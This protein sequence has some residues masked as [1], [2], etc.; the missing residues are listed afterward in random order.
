MICLFCKSDSHNSKTIEHIIPHSLGNSKFTLPKGIVCDKCNHYFAVKIE[1][2]VLEL[3]F[4]INIRF[5][6]GIE[7]KK[8]RVPP[9]EVV[10]PNGFIGRINRDS[11][12]VSTVQV[13]SESFNLIE[14]ELLNEIKVKLNFTPPLDNLHLSRL[15]AK[16]ALEMFA[17]RL[18]N[19]SHY[20][21]FLK[22]EDNLG[23]IR[24]YARF[25]KRG[26]F[27]NY[28]VRKIYQENEAFYD[29]DNQ[30]YDMIY[31]CDFFFT[32]PGA[33]YSE[34]YF[35]I[36]LKGIEFV[37]NMGGPSIDGYLEWLTQ[38]NYDCPLY[39]DTSKYEIGRT[40]KIGLAHMI[41]QA[42]LVCSK[43]YII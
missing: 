9:G 25:N 29:T 2:I 28:N 32:K 33:E 22:D 14:K 8:G 1:K 42:F 38:N 19:S 37:I 11:P 27:W 30:K 26:S 35:I 16:I 3:D 20:N 13:D 24:E 10:F 12:R 17:N 39:S 23:A 18:L 6:N 36:I 43:H 41:P 5:R 4:F 7:S 31:E 15:L 40:P 34:V 21:D